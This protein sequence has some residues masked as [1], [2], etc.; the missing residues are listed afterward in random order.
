M[1][2]IKVRNIILGD[3]IPKI[4]VP[5][6][7]KTK[8]QI[9]EEAKSFCNLEIDLV[10]WRVDWFEYATDSNQVLD[11][12]IDLSLA[13]G[14]IPI[15]FT[16]RTQNEGGNLAINS[17]DYINLNKTIAS[18]GLVDMIDVEIFMGDD[19]STE[20]IE[21]AHKN[22]IIAVASNHDFEKTPAR[23]EI[24]SRLRKMQDLGADISK[25]AVMPNSASDVLTLLEAT[26][27][28]NEKYAKT[29]IITMSM[30]GIGTISRL[31]GEIFGSCLTFAAAKKAS[32]PGQIGI[33]ELRNTLK[34]IHK[35]FTLK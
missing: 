1:K 23:D 32:A 17:S 35:N 28:M 7:E 15:L 11:V 30:S 22:N 31:S 3:G 10:E 13:L 12:L 4:C 27:I 21:A 14:N 29:P 2:T 18:S 16:F 20:I 34:I 6:V 26:T 33:N 24:V 9:I 8:N 19:V 5:I 25:I